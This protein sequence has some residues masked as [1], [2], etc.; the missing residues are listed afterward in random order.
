MTL[1]ELLVA[2]AITAV[3]AL[4]GW[5][6]LGTLV[7][8]Q[9]TVH[10]Q[11]GAWGEWQTS[12]AQWST[13]LDQLQDTQVVPPLL[14]DGHILR[15]VRQAPRTGQTPSALLVVAWALRPD[16]AAP[17]SGP[18]WFRWSSPPLRQRAALEQAWRSAEQWAH[19]PSPEL[20]RDATALPAAVGWQLYYHRGGAWS[21]PLSA[22][23]APGAE[24]GMP[25]GIR[26]VLTL[27]DTGP[28]RGL[29]TRDW[30]RPTVGGGKAG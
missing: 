28:T 8:T 30:V 20:H 16:P 24:G 29:I 22:S 2:L 10:E 21:H 6:S 4:M 27:G 15:L 1:I 18:R 5:R 19:T 12:L 9:T 3:L 7:T 26:L 13:D 14:F 11:T 25:E 23:D 17:D